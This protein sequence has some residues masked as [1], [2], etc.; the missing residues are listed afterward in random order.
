MAVKVEGPMWQHAFESGLLASGVLLAVALIGPSFGLHTW[1]IAAGEGILGLIAGLFTL[2]ATDSMPLAGYWFFAG[3]YAA[4]WSVAARLLDVWST[5]SLGLLGLGFLIFTPY[6]MFLWSSYQAELARQAG[7][8]KAITSGME[9]QSWQKRFEEIE[10]PGIIVTD[11]RPTFAGRDIHLRLPMHGRV[12]LSVLKN[13]VERM[14]TAWNKREGAIRFSKAGKVGRAEVIMHLTEKEVL[15]QLVPYPVDDLVARTINEP[16]PIGMLETGE[17]AMVQFREIAA[18]IVGVRGSGKSNLLNVLIS[19]LAQCVD[20]VIWMIDLKGGR[21]AAPWLEPWVAD[22]TGRTR[23]VLDWVATTPE[24]A[25][26]MLDCF[27]A[28]IDLRSRHAGGK[29]KVIPSTKEPAIVLVVDEMAKVFGQGFGNKAGSGQVTNFQLAGKAKDAVVVGRSEAMDLILATQRGTV[30]MTGDGDLKSQLQLRIG[31][32]TTTTADAMAVYAGDVQAQKRMVQLSKIPG[33]GIIERNDELVPF[34]VF[35]IEPDQ[36]DIRRIAGWAS[37]NTA[38]APEPML[39]SAG[40]AA[41]DD[42]WSVRGQDLIGQVARRQL[43]EDEDK[44]FEEITRGLE[45]EGLNPV[46]VRVRELVATAG[47]TGISP[48]R[49]AQLLDREGYKEGKDVPPDERLPARETIQ[50]WLA[51]DVESG[52][53]KTRNPNTPGVRYYVAPVRLVPGENN[54]TGTDG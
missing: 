21:A 51:A 10:L 11:I 4:G 9:Q 13:S 5:A 48:K 36:G 47:L 22:N 7:K 38:A 49:V 1:Q 31:L 39:V 3:L 24:E 32:G 30:T 26:I 43:P 18:L 34:K 27:N 42:R 44:T 33:A 19:Q 52:M 17:Y 50:R 25:E 23:P 16:F 53:F 12:T 35:R 8:Q 40:G 2:K 29:E 41:Y 37:R 28:W 20:C 46:R 6:G 14:E 15:E 54:D 45:S